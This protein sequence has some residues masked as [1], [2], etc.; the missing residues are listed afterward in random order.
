MTHIH[1]RYI[2]RAILVQ[3]FSTFQTACLHDPIVSASGVAA[4][5]IINTYIPL[6]WTGK[7]LEGILTFVL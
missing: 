6:R 5:S 4:G 7:L 1:D 3:G 2:I